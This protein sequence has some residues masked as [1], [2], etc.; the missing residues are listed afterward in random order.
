[1]CITDCAALFTI[2]RLNF[3]TVIVVFFVFKLIAKALFSEQVQK[4]NANLLT[5][6]LNVMP[7]KQHQE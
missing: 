2:F 3:G 7:Y 5:R 4:K 6:Q 1:M